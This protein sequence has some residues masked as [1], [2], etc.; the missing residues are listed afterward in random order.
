MPKTNLKRVFYYLLVPH[1]RQMG[2]PAAIRVQDKPTC[3]YQVK[4][5]SKLFVRA[6]PSAG[7]WKTETEF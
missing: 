2:A 3:A 4:H 5:L 6:G 1:P 7:E